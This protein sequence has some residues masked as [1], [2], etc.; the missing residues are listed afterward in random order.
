MNRT[1]LTI[2]VLGVVGVASLGLAPLEALVPPDLGVAVPRVVFLI[3]PAIL[4][5]AAAAL[6]CWAAPKMGLEAPLISALTSGAP[7][8]DRFRSAMGPALIG[9]VAVA[10]ILLGY[11]LLTRSAFA[12]P[13]DPNFAKLAA[14]QTPL[15]SKLLYG[16]IAEEVLA[17]WGIMSGVALAALKLGAGRNRALWIGCAI[18]ALLFGLGHLPLLFAAVPAPPAWLIAA[19]IIGNVGPGLI[20]GWLFWRRGLESAM[21]AHATAHLLATLAGAI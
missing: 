4:V 11:A 15:L 5:L 3:Q 6:G 14:F 8:A 18:A 10:F 2:A 19:V 9:G 7:V 12:N 17:R 1:C 13:A 16:G 21:I 20:F